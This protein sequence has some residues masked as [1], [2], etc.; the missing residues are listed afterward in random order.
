M[1]QALLGFLSI[2]LV[3]SLSIGWFRNLSIENQWLDKPTDR[4]SHHQA[5][6]HIGGIVMMFML[7]LLTLI[8]VLVDY[9]S[10]KDSLIWL[11]I[12][13][14]LGLIGFIDDIKDLPKRLRLIA[15]IVVATC[16]IWHFGG[17][18]SI[19]LGSINIEFSLF[20]YLLGFIWVVGFINMYN[21]MDGING[22]AGCQ[23]LIAGLIFAAWLYYLNQTGESMLFLGVASTAIGFLYWNFSP[24]KVFMGDSGSTMLGGLFAVI[25]LQLHNQFELS[26]LFPALL[27]AWFLIDTSVTFAKR[28]FR[29]EKVWQAHRQH[30]YQKLAPNPQDHTKVTGM[31]SLITLIISGI[32]TA[33]L[34]YPDF[35]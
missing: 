9:L 2:A 10:W 21:F 7:V 30:F 12:L 11:L 1:W 3:T 20:S 27:F 6:P 35:L 14:L 29:G 19:Q 5:V 25:S 34:L 26:I 16:A 13:L 24:A 31:I 23:A 32:I 4:G 18:N 8:L 28:L 15:Q 22:L 17:I 33:V